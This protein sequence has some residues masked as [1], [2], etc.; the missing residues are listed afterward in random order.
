MTNLKIDIKVITPTKENIKE[1]E[2]IRYDAVGH[3]IPEQYLTSSNCAE[4]MYNAELLIFGMYLDNILV[5]GCYVSDSFNTLFIDQL[6]VKKEFQETGLYLGRHL[7]KY[8]LEN[9][10]AVEKYFH[11]KPS[12]SQLFFIDKKS[13]NTYEKLGYEIENKEIGLMSKKLS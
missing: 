10:E 11:Y 9:R 6:F 8:I 1:C 2:K 13:K 4:K 7:L 12:K 3:T 5:A